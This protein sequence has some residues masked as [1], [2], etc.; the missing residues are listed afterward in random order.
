[1]SENKVVNSEEIMEDVIVADAEIVDS[2]ED[3]SELAPLSSNSL[4][5]YDEATQK[6][7]LRIANEIDVTQFEKIMA[8]G[9]IPIVRSFEAAGKILQEA[10]GTSAD[11]EV[12]KMVTE[13]A[14]QA[15]DSYN[16]VI[17]EP[18]FFQKLVMK[19]T[20]GLKSESKASICRVW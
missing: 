17:E 13:L 18:N 19:I 10:Q 8:Y 3:T 4:A 20:S 5:H 15:K 1:M 2:K 14:K 6:E 11:Q 12:V 7:I 9:S 16:L